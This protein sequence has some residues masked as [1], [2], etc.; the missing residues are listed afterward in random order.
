MASSLQ[1]TSLGNFASQVL[2]VLV[3]ASGPCLT[4]SAKNMFISYPGS[5]HMYTPYQVIVKTI[6][7]SKC[8][9]ETVDCLAV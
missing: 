3:F 5:C 1:T 6:K 7:H 9:V 4:N 2:K 8:S